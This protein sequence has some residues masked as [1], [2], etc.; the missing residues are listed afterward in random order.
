MISHSP[1][2]K[3]GTELVL[4]VLCM[5]SIHCVGC[6]TNELDRRA[7][8]REASLATLAWLTERHEFEKDPEVLRQIERIKLLLS[9]FSAQS[10]SIQWQIMV[11]RTPEPNAFSSGAGVIVITRALLER[12]ETE[13]QFAAI[14]AHEMS[15]HLLGHNR[16]ALQ[17]ADDQPFPTIV[18][19]LENELEAD[20]LS[21]R[22]LAQAGYNPHEALQ[23]LSVVYRPN[24]AA[25]CLPEWQQ[26]RL[27]QLNRLISRYSE[28]YGLTVTTREFNKLRQHLAS[29]RTSN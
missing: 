11:I 14:L 9:S 20:E 2:S 4:V 5:I 23:A 13:A 6:S 16:S 15:H 3:S 21:V 24:A 19:S 27:V 12:C 29:L 18:L 17:T 8:E 22:I 7:N 25:G 28:T 1:F 26:A 10:R